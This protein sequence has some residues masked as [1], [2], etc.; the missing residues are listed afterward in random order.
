MAVKLIRVA[1]EY[2]KAALQVARGYGTA[3]PTDS[4][5]ATKATDSN[6]VYE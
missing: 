2:V 1:K 4:D 6:K 5:R 3:A